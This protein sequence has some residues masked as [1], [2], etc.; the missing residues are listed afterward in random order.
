MAGYRDELDAA[1]ARVQQLEAEVAGLR[2]E[3]QQSPELR[4]RLVA[5]E[6]HRTE[7]LKT[8]RRAQQSARTRLRVTFGLA[9]AASAA[10]IAAIVAMGD[11][12]HP[13]HA[14]LMSLVV[15]SFIVG[16]VGWIGATSE[17][18][19]A[20]ELSAIEDEIAAVKAGPG[21]AHVV[22]GVRVG[23]DVWVAE[24][25]GEKEASSEE[26]KMTSEV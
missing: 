5:L 8:L 22:E 4:T 19:R 13:V 16:F 24:A 26:D 25:E 20:R 6:R 1:L 17:N 9:L 10:F 21:G 2:S 11:A 23:K 15:S 18:A 7:A 14:A 3:L 12:G